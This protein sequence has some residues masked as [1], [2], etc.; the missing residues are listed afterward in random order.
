MNGMGETWRSL[1]EDRFPKK[2]VRYASSTLAAVLA[3]H[4]VPIQSRLWDLCTLVGVDLGGCK[5]EE[6]KQKV[7]M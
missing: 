6:K 2:T 3:D 7:V 4:V 5:Y 1:A